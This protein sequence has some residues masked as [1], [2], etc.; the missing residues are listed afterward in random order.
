MKH[1]WVNWILVAVT[2]LCLVG[3][4]AA[5]GFR[6]A[7]RSSSVVL[8]SLDEV[9]A[10][11]RAGQFSAAR[12]L[13]EGYLKANP[14]SQSAHLLMAQLATEASSPLPDQA[15]E[16]LRRIR[17]EG[18]KQAALVKFLEGKAQY[19][20]KRYD[21]AE[22]RWNEALRL[23]SVV[24]E[25]GWAML[26]LLDLEGR[27]EEAHSL[28]M[29]LHEV[30]PDPRDR[31]KLLLELA[32]IDIDRVAP[33]SQVAIFEALV[34]QHPENLRLAQVLG[35]A[36]VHDSRGEEGLEVLGDALR[37]HPDSPDAW[38][39]WLTGLYDAYQFDKLASEFDRLP[40]AMAADPRFAKHEGIVAQNARDW[41]RATRAFRRAFEFEPYNGVV[42]YRLRQALSMAG[43]KADAEQFDQVY[44]A[45]QSAFKELRAVH[46]KALAEPALGVGPLPELYHRLALLRE[47]MGRPDE[48]RAW[49]R[50]V[51]RDAPADPVSLAALERLK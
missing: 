31:V 42:G 30:E 27:T 14:G 20:Q 18:S 15:L 35:L 5:L 28:G 45:F 9:R 51:L 44:S 3:G 40:R 41:P 8:A 48:A 36:L 13:L 26:D 10:L 47:Q 34:R 25:A 22:D 29:R 4:F 1:R 2:V 46:R 23:D 21:L 43:E 17:S 7:T 49:H 33:G 39:A 37:R 24:P 16:H 38:D 32:R 50:L 12:V 11:A 6:H 19:Q